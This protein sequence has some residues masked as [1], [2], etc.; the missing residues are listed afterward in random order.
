[1]KR[2]KLVTAYDGTNY[3]GSQIQ[4]NGE[5]IEGVLKM[6]LSSL[7]KEEVQIIGASRTDAG[8]H[9]RGNV[10]VFDTESRIPSD[11]FTYALNARLPEDIRIQDSEEVPLDFHPRHQD[12]VKTYEY[13]VLNR[14][15]PLPEYRLHAHFT[16]ETLNIERMQLACKYFIG[17]HDFASFCA[18]GSQ[19]ESTVR[20][21][22]DL[23]VKKEGDLVT[24]SVTGNGFLYNMVRIIAGTLLKVGSG[25]FAPEDMEKIIEGKDRSLA[26]PTAPA[27]GL[28][29]VEIRYPNY[30]K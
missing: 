5:T 26:G 27:K 6:E 4:N 15:L 29:L 18:A 21:I 17:E 1:M 30:Q 3:H 9:A 16:Y 14:K 19:V 2:I 11:K 22:Y 12:T 20:E 10:F 8:V 24:I 23:H 7:L 13:R 28:T 25:H